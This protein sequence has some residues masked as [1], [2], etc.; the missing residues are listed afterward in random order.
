M[1]EL[2]IARMHRRCN[3]VLRIRHATGT[4]WG[5]QDNY[6]PS[7]EYK[8]IYSLRL[9]TLLHSHPSIQGYNCSDMI[10]KGKEGHPKVRSCSETTQAWEE[11][12]LGKNGTIEDQQ[13]RKNIVSIIKIGQGASCFETNQLFQWIWVYCVFST[14]HTHTQIH[15][16]YLLSK[17]SGQNCLALKKQSG[18]SE[19][20]AQNNKDNK[21]NL[22]QFSLSRF[23]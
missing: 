7:C 18:H 15:H 19:N 14:T 9:M 17:Q 20:Q 1:I 13:H 22:I 6:R 16:A 11:T 4:Q 21:F 10:R 3:V 12:D 23:I 5:F 8:S 2:L